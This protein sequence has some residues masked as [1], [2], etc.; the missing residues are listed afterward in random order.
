MY[1]VPGTYNAIIY[2]MTLKVE[3]TNILPYEKQN[4]FSL[5]SEHFLL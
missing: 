1:D 4:Y 3:L 2:S 5:F